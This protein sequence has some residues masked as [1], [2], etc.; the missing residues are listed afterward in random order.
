[1]LSRPPESTSHG[2]LSKIQ[3]LGL[4]PSSMESETGEVRGRGWGAGHLCFTQASWWL[5]CTMKSENYYHNQK[6]RCTETGENSENN[7]VEW[8]VWDRINKGIRITSFSKRKPVAMTFTRP[9]VYEEL[10]PRKSKQM[11]SISPEGR[12]RR[13]YEL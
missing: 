13:H 7:E 9:Q 10:F 11:F 4:Y 8:K 5:W 1:M 2:N 3:I 12:S 6:K